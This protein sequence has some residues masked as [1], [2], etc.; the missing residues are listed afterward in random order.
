MLVRIMAAVI[1]TAAGASAG[2][3]YS[4]R[5]RDSCGR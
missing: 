4:L 1:F 3:A 5:L 2:A